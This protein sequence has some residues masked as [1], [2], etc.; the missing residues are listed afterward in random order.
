MTTADL[1]MRP[2]K[3]QRPA[4][5]LNVHLF[6]QKGLH[7]GQMTH[8]AFP[9]I[10]RD[11][12]NFVDDFQPQIE[13]NHLMMKPYLRTFAAAVTAICISGAA[14]TATILQIENTDDY[15]ISLND[16]NTQVAATFFT[17]TESYT[18]VSIS[19]PI[20]CLACEGS[21]VLHSGPV[22]VG[23]TIADTVAG[24]AFNTSVTNLFSG[25][26]LGPGTYSLI[27]GVTSGT[28]GWSGASVPTTTTDGN[29]SDGLD[30]VGASAEFF[31]PAS[32]FTPTFSESQL[33]YSITGDIVAL[34]P[35][36][37]PLPAS[38]ALLLGG[39]LGLG[40]LRRKASSAHVL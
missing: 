4:R 37:V 10:R 38:A 27:V 11:A 26:S 35:A 30:V 13:R 31:I 3:R 24:F 33:A 18:N 14:S 23:A 16:G 39:L 19:A 40:V 2:V 12:I 22:G 7:L 6:G 8:P 17:L 32:V 21:I 25:L 20:L 29:S 28:G 36:A 15:G 1:G 34:P 5:K 9:I